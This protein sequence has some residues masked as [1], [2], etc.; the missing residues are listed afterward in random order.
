MRIYTLSTARSIG[1]W[2]IRIQYLVFI[3]YNS[4]YKHMY[5]SMYMQ[6]YIDKHCTIYIHTRVCMGIG[7]R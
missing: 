7:E 1:M 6:K 3:D 5:I 4:L 2:P